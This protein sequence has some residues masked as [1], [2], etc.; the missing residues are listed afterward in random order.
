LQR[1]ICGDIF[2]AHGKRRWHHGHERQTDHFVDRRVS[3]SVIDKPNQA[4]RIGW[5]GI[6]AALT[7][8]LIWADARLFIRLRARIPQPQLFCHIPC[9]RLLLIIPESDAVLIRGKEQVI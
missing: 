4:V 5:T 1:R 8:H 7:L 6:R 3:I 2:N 9:N